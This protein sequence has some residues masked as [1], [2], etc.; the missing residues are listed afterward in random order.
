LGPPLRFAGG[1]VEKLRLSITRKLAEAG[2][3]SQENAV[4]PDEADL[5]L[6]EREWLIYLAGGMTSRIRKTSDDRYYLRKT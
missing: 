6:S 5:T 4:T 2:A 1:V 3:S